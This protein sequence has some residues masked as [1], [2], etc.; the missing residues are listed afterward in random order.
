MSIVYRSQAIDA[1][2]LVSNGG[3]LI[4]VDNR[5]LESKL[6][7]RLIVRPQFPISIPYTFLVEHTPFCSYN[8]FF[9]LRRNRDF[10]R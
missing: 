2:S 10:D 6:R 4:S 1:F 3:L 9:L 8:R 7:R 5:R